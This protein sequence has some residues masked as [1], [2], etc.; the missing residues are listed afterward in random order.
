VCYPFGFIPE[1]MGYY[2][3][4]GNNESKKLLLMQTAETRVIERFV[5]EQSEVSI[6]L[7][8][9]ARSKLLH[10]YKKTAQ[11]ASFELNKDVARQYWLKALS[12]QPW[13]LEMYVGLAWNFL[14]P[15]RR[16]AL[17]WYWSKLFPKD[18]AVS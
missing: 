13:G 10:L 17:K 5:S 6:I 4:H 15:S 3:L 9:I 11:L 16:R 12:I 1:S 2:R 7:N 14:S 8:G 18:Q